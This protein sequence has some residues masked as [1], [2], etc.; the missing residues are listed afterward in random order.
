MSDKVALSDMIVF[1][2]GDADSRAPETRFDAQY[3]L[4]NA[5]QPAG[6][7]LSRGFG[8]PARGCRMAG[9][10]ETRRLGP[11]GAGFVRFRFG[12]R[13][14]GRSRIDETR[15]GVLETDRG[16]KADRA[17]LAPTPTIPRRREH[18]HVER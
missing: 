12:V 3:E 15:A 7:P 6:A 9:I 17:A 4:R 18:G 14:T 10:A 16:A 5:L 1:I 11:C 8:P 13:E 2:E